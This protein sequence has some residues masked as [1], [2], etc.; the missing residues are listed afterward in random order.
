MVLASL[1]RLEDD[2]SFALD[3]ADRLA[4]GRYGVV[5]SLSLN[6]NTVNPDVRRIDYTVPANP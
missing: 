1:G 3:L 2:G 6:G 5:A 4:P